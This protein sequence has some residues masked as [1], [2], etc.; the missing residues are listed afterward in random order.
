M[1]Q[2][3]RGI[4]ILLVLVLVFH[5]LPMQIFAEQL[6][7]DET[8]T[9][10]DAVKEAVAEPAHI[11][12]EVSE[13]RTEYSKE[14][15]LSNGLHMA[16]LYP[17]A[18]HYQ[19]D[20]QWA[21]IDNTLT[22]HADGTVRN[23]AGVWDVRLPG[24]TG[25]KQSLTISKDGYTLTFGLPQKLT[26]LST[27]AVGAEQ[28]F[29]AAQAGSVAAQVDAKL[30]VS[31]AKEDALH[32]ET[33]IDGL[34]SRVTYESLHSNTNVVYDLTSNK[35]KESV[36]LRQYDP[37]LAGFRYVLDVGTMVPVLDEA[38]HIT[39]YDE[40]QSKVIMVI[41][42]PYMMDA[43]GEIST[44]VQVALTGKGSSYTLTYTLPKQWLA[45]ENRQ[46]PVL[47]D[48]TVTADLDVTNVRD[49]SVA[50]NATFS[51]TS[52]VLE[53]GYY[54]G[55]GRQR[56]YL[57]YAELPELTSADV[58]VE[59][60]MTLYKFKNSASSAPIEVHKVENT[61][62]SETITWANKPAYNPIVED[63]VI[64]QNARYYSWDVTDIVQGW[65]SDDTNTG[66]LFKASDAVENAQQNNFKQ[67]YSSD[68]SDYPTYMPTLQITFR[69]TNGLEDIWSYTSSSAG[70]AG[71]GYVNNYCGNLVWVREDLGYHGLRMP[72]TINHVFNSNDAKRNDFGLGL[73]WRTNYNQLV[74]QWD[75]NTSYYVWEDGD[76]T[77]H[78]FKHYSG[79]TY[80]DDDAKKTAN[81]QNFDDIKLTLTVGGTGDEAYVIEDKLGNTSYFDASG[82]LKS[83]KNNQ[84][85][86][87][88][89]EVRYISTSSKLINKITDG[90]GRVYDF[91]YTNNLLSRISF[92]SD[93]NTERGYVTFTYN[94]NALT[95]ITDADDG[96]CTYTYKN[97]MLESATDV[98]GYKLIYEYTNGGSYAPYRVKSIKEKHGTAT[99][100]HMTISYGNNFTVFTDV[101]NGITQTHQFNDWGDT[102]AIMDDEGRAQYM[103]YARND[104]DDTAGKANQLTLVSKMQNTVVNLVYDSSFELGVEWAKV[105]A[106]DTVSFGFDSAEKYL[107]S[108]SLKLQNS[109]NET[110]YQNSQCNLDPGQTYTLSGYIKTTGAA[111]AQLGLVGA[112]NLNELS[113]TEAK[114]ASGWTRVELHYTNTGTTTKAVRIAFRGQGNEAV[115]LDCVQL[116]K[117]PTASRYNLVQN[118]EFRRNATGWSATGGETADGIVTVAG[119]AAP[120]LQD[121]AYK[122]T[123][124]YTQNKFISQT[125][126]ISGK[127]GDN[128]VFGG[129]AKG[130]SASLK[131]TEDSE[132]VE[133]RFRLE[134]TVNYDDG[135]SDSAEASFN[136]DVHEWQ[137]TSNV[138]TPKSDYSSVKVYA[139][140]G[141]NAGTVY[142]DG[143][144]VFQE[145][146]GCS[147]EYNDDG[148]LESS[149]DEQGKE[150]TYEYN[151][152]GDLVEI[153]ESD[154]KK[155]T[156]TYEA[157]THN[158]L[159]TTVTYQISTNT[160]KIYTYT[161]TY[162][163]YGNQTSVT[164][165]HGGESITERNTYAEEGNL[166][167][168]TTDALD[169]TTTYDY[170]EDT[171][172]LE[173]V[174]YPGDT[175]TTQTNYT[176]DS[177]Q[178]RT[179]VT[180][181]TDANQSLYARYTYEDDQL[182]TLVTPSTTYEFTFGNFALKQSVKA[183]DKTLVNYTYESG[184]NRLTKQTY[185][186]GQYV[187]FQ[188]DAHG[189]LTQKS[190]ADGSTTKYY[191]DNCNQIAKMVDSRSGITTVYYYDLIGR[192]VGYHETSTTLDHRVTYSYDE[193]DRPK[194]MKETVNGYT[195]TYTYTYNKEDKLASMTVDGITLNYTYD[196]FGRLSKQTKVYDGKTVKTNNIQ[197]TGTDTTTSNQISTF[198]SWEYTYDSKGYIK[199][200]KPDTNETTYT[201]NSAGYL[202]REDNQKL[203]KSFR[204]YYN[205]AGN[206]IAKNTY[207]YTTGE[208]G[209]AID[210]LSYTYG[211]N[212]G[213]GDLLTEIDGMTATYDNVGNLVNLGNIETFT[214]KRGRE[215]AAHAVAVELAIITQ[216]KDC[217]GVSGANASFSVKASGKDLTYQWQYKEP[218]GSTWIDSVAETHNTSAISGFYITSGRSGRLYRCVITDGDGNQLISNTAE[219]IMVPIAIT[220]QPNNFY[221]PE[222]SAVSFSLTAAGENLSYLWQVS[223][224]DGA[225]WSTSGAAVNN[226]STLTGFNATEARNGRM[227]RCIVSDDQGNQVISNTATLNMTS[228]AIS[229]NPSNAWGI[230]GDEVSFSVRAYGQNLTYQWQYSSNG[231]TSWSNS[232]AEGNKTN[233]LS[234]LT[235]NSARLGMQYRCKVSNGTQELYSNV[236]QIKLKTKTWRNSYNADGIRI[237]RTDG[238]NTYTYIYDGSR[239][240]RVQYNG[241]LV[242]YN[243]DESGRPISLRYNNVLYF[244]DT[245]LQGDVVGIRETEDNERVVNYVY[246]A[247]GKICSITGS[248]KDSLGVHNVLRYRGYVYD[249]E[250]G[251][252]YLQS[253][254][255]NPEW[256]R[257]ISADGFVATG[258]GFA[259]NNMFVYCGNNPVNYVDYTGT[260]YFD[261]KG[262]WCHDNWEYIGG[263]QRKPSP[264][265]ATYESSVGT[266]VVTNGAELTEETAAFYSDVHSSLVFVRDCRAC[267]ANCPGAEECNPNIQIINS[268]RI[269]SRDAQYEML[270]ILYK[271]DSFYLSRHKWGRTIDSLLIEWDIHNR[272][273]QL[274]S[275]A[276]TAK[277]TDFDY[278][279]EGEGHLYF[280]Q[281]AFFRLFQ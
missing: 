145:E 130:K 86:P 247:Y 23:A 48:P 233:T 266:V 175:A 257:F 159:S 221:G 7:M 128:L 265:M 255:Y 276:K 149:K 104:K 155:T 210:T 172:L 259:G 80:V 134:L 129:W 244:V 21:Q 119:G 213:W 280:L 235:I 100:G 228:F 107:G 168:T 125:I 201:Y 57:K 5:M 3:L 28:T 93:D 225:T 246:D 192:L 194:A 58:V 249:Q 202:I 189:R 60:K 231:G 171:G 108:K 83:I 229:R 158:L 209:T 198:N 207:E 1:K 42:A 188:Y 245:N 181:K 74:Y 253:R 212:D 97:K 273:A 131:K 54:E 220:N 139:S 68:Y 141:Y 142:F 263:Y 99:G 232:P 170:N 178:R 177:M 147:Y 52:N 241:K 186:N 204:W 179:A 127:A 258:Q 20:G 184:T 126:P 15:L 105:N 279:E 55:E 148:K 261:A 248:L 51:Y 91:T 151:D 156:N 197:Y 61:W 152:A 81:D 53:T 64:C 96:V 137:F 84:A 236:V 103:G 70:R 89:V 163:A 251:L 31:Q 215:L 118:G 4:S 223:T 230:L 36:V 124:N 38:G 160:Q 174:C 45:E 111:T 114:S 173:H 274:G 254:Y 183:G 35:V 40:T 264:V 154:G 143:I 182:K 162:D 267:E 75:E 30:D 211:S 82:R 217:K 243:Y 71:T 216:P 88:S 271:Y 193:Q 62:E 26:A 39:F 77:S 12:G 56:T 140:F 237:G 2:I 187:A 269:T 18:V 14:F 67:F 63:F 199:T 72:V 76:G 122:M 268:D 150:T 277:H 101:I 278:K 121:T 85:T 66:M 120:A 25:T 22:A 11:L 112:S 239:L 272:Y 144:Q 165:T 34:S 37:S 270:G 106:S 169:R 136:E 176:Y 227:Y 167:A 94:G 109:A 218:N 234:G 281:K 191:Y 185:G 117:N 242:R 113:F 250:T 69:N 8:A 87:S 226:A 92:K 102:T 27:R 240:T 238:T 73:G 153:E 262:N 256:G 180:S 135:T 224:D 203:G 146:F 47:L 98:D 13:K 161:Y 59:A 19:K 24:Q 157:D 10:T 123:G 132:D 16:V 44:D 65:Y 46:W 195:K 166:L 138:L 164:T 9:Q 196:A 33:V 190:Y 214:W 41:A 275:I 95:T 219:L 32:P 6:Q 200:V 222:G 90:A 43:E 78:Y 49:A 79:N 116:E 29:T 50:E 17:N 260:C 206:I 115:Y 208:L 110:I 205:S 133:K 252:Y